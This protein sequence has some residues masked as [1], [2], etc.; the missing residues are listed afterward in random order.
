MSFFLKYLGTLFYKKLRIKI[1]VSFLC[2]SGP[3]PHNALLKKHLLTKKE[4]LPS[5]GG[6]KEKKYKK[7]QRRRYQRTKEENSKNKGGG[8]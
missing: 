8:I 1:V 3:R 5:R 4:K 7:E 2:E 6:T